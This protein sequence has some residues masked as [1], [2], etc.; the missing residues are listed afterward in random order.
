MNLDQNICKPYHTL[1]LPLRDSLSHLINPCRDDLIQEAWEAV[2]F[3]L[4]YYFDPFDLAPA[5]L[6]TNEKV[7]TLIVTTV[8]ID[9]PPMVNLRDS[10]Y[11]TKVTW[12]FWWHYEKGYVKLHI[13]NGAESRKVMFQL[14]P[15]TMN[16]GAPA[17][18]TAGAKTVNSL[19]SGVWLLIHRW[20]GCTVWCLL[21]SSWGRRS[22]SCWSGP[23]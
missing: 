9:H 13:F 6:T 10:L 23:A 20:R 19:G 15:G 14:L 21:S 17:I 5:V 4:W 12:S 22:G 16:L 8:S 2:F 11:L 7:D 1:A 18:S 3:S